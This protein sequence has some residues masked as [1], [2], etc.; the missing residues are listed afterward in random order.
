MMTGI[1]MPTNHNNIPRMMNLGGENNGGRMR[2][3]AWR[4]DGSTHHGLVL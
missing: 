2:G 3:D 1:G 4:H